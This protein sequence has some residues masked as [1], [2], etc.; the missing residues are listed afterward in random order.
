MKCAMREFPD[1]QQGLCY[2]RNHWSMQRDAVTRKQQS[3]V[4]FAVLPCLVRHS[5]ILLLGTIAYQ[6]SRFEGH[7]YHRWR[8]CHQHLTRS[9]LWTL[10]T[11]LRDER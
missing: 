10:E 3:T 1:L 8:H 11:L 2:F 9:S 4:A 6:T 7:L 5:Q